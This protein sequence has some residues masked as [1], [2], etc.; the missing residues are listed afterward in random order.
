VTPLIEALGRAC[1]DFVPSEYEDTPYMW[2]GG[3]VRH[4][5]QARLD[6]RE[7]EVHA[8][9]AVIERQLEADRPGGKLSDD[10]NLAVVGFLEDLQNGNLHVPG[11]R[12]ADFRTNL[13][14][15]SLERWEGLNGFWGAVEHSKSGR[16]PD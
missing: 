8:V 3:F 1:P 16:K 9:F 14:P 6:G 5:A 11:S 2:M 15:R 4:V 10:S 12:P 7:A 13:G